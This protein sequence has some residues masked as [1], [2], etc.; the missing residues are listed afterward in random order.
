MAFGFPIG[1]R[2]HQPS[3]RLHFLVNLRVV[4]NLHLVDR[5]AVRRKFNC[6]PN[7]LAPILFCLFHHPRNQ[8]DVDLREIQLAREIIGTVNFTRPMRAA[9]NIQNVI[10]EVFHA[11]AEPG[12]TQIANHLEFVVG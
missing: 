4:R 8:I 6:L 10:A 12:D 7:T 9:V 1:N 5:H 2:S 11:E 3:L